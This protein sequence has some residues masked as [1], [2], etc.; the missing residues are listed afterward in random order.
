MPELN[1]VV[2]GLKNLEARQVIQSLVHHRPPLVGVTPVTPA[3]WVWVRPRR[4]VR[5][6]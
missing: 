5:V 3:S 1:G 6:R 4:I 2:L